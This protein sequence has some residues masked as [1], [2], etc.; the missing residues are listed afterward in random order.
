LDLVLGLNPSEL[1]A[2]TTWQSTSDVVNAKWHATTAILGMLSEAAYRS[3]EGS[4]MYS[5]TLAPA[6]FTF[7]KSINV[8][9]GL[10]DWKVFTK[11]V[12]DVQCTVLATSTNVVVAVRDSEGAR[13]W[14]TTNFDTFDFTLPAWFPNTVFT[15]GLIAIKV[16]PFNEAQHQLVKS[17][18][19]S[20]KPRLLFH[21]K[22]KPQSMP[23]AIATLKPTRYG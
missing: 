21:P 16:W 1:T 4:A 18:L 19:A 12:L 5:S 14:I 9:V 8:D 22:S 11:P 10:F 6:G 13:D 3:L 7:V 23:H 17:T 2:I 15:E 20:L